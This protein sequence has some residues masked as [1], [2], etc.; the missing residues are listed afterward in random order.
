MNSFTWH[1]I[2]FREGV[3]LW[4]NPFVHDTPAEIPVILAKPTFFNLIL[5]AERYEVSSW[6]RISA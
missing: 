1:G 3:H 2:T 5:L 4:S 6:L